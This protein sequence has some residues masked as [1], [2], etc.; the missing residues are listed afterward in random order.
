M[1]MVVT[2]GREPCECDMRASC[3]APLRH[4]SVW[5]PQNSYASRALVLLPLVGAFLH[6]FRQCTPDHVLPQS[7][8][9]A[10][11]ASV[12][13]TSSNPESSVLRNHP[14]PATFS[15]PKGGAF[16]YNGMRAFPDSLHDAPLTRAPRV[17]C[18]QGA[19]STV[20]YRQR[21]GPAFSRRLVADR[22]LGS[23]AVS[24]RGVI[25]RLGHLCLPSTVLTAFYL[26]L[27]LGCCTAS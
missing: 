17:R 8:Q 23:Y 3:G 11:Y 27:A 15:S 10:Y 2:Y 6:R 12:V 4:N 25:I 7:R 19:E 22:W 18:M 20:V 9:S 21:L 16:S 26:G 1:R 13:S 14:W 5:T 24:V